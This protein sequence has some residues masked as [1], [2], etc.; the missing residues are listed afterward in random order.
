[1]LL[2]GGVGCCAQ[3]TRPHGRWSVMRR[4]GLFVYALV[5]FVCTTSNICLAGALYMFSNAV[6]EARREDFTNLSWRQKRSMD[7][8]HGLVVH[9]FNAYQCNLRPPASSGETGVNVTCMNATWFTQ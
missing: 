4:V 9:V 6:A 8:L 5:L 3:R 2:M 1:M 7:S